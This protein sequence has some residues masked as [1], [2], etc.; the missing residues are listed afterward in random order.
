M[1]RRAGER[2]SR[3]VF[4]TFDKSLWLASRTR[5]NGGG[6]RRLSSGL[7]DVSDWKLNKYENLNFAVKHLYHCDPNLWP[8]LTGGQCSEVAHCVIKEIGASI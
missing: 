2:A 8:L 6:E 3:K 4:G 7:A 1:E 5:T